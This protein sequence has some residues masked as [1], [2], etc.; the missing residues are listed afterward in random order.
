ML[1]QPWLS[2]Q[3]LRI[4]SAIVLALSAISILNA[5][6]V[7]AP[8]SS[9]D[10]VSIDQAWQKAS[11]KYDAARAALL[12]EVDGATTRGPFR[13]DSGIPSKVLGPWNPTGTQ[14]SGFSF[15]GASTPCQPSAMNGI[16]E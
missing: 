2:S 3:L 15:I 9:Q 11:S 6:N 10:P 16:H 1:S 7:T 8:T 13:P 14:N 5:Q 4:I 12:K